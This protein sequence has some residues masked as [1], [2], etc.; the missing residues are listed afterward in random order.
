[1]TDTQLLA[2]MAAIIVA[3]GKVY[4][5][6]APKVALNILRLV[7]ERDALSGQDKF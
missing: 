3:G 4:T 5:G 1:M 7:K 2:L 6:D